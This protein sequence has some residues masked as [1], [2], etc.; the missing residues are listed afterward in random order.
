M[1]T[2]GYGVK[3]ASRHPE[4][5]ARPGA[6][7]RSAGLGKQ[8]P[9]PHLTLDCG[10]PAPPPLD[11]GLRPPDL[12]E[13]SSV[14]SASGFVVQPGRR[15][16]GGARCPEG[17]WDVPRSDSSRCAGA[18]GPAG[19][20]LASAGPRG[21]GSR[22]RRIPGGGGRRDRHSHRRDRRGLGAPA[23]SAAWVPA[24]HRGDRQ[25]RPRGGDRRA[26]L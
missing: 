23:A 13:Q 10:L 21:L 4:P 20:Q 25:A 26:R 6:V 19:G 15:P 8:Q 17:T 5:G 2:P 3:V 12:R 1:E 7:S 9:R 11:L 24:G 22:S 16:E 18:E 14:A